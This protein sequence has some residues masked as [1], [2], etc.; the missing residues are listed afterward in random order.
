MVIIYMICFP[1]FFVN[2]HTGVYVTR[3]KC[4]WVVHMISYIQRMRIL[5]VK[6]LKG[7]SVQG[8]ILGA[9]LKCLHLVMH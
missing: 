1:H 4:V 7:A 8:R 6:G 3:V 9:F 2:V 5:P